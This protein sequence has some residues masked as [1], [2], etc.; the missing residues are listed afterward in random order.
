[1]CA[2]AGSWGPEESNHLQADILT[3]GRRVA[4]LAERDGIPLRLLGGVAIHLR[5]G[6][7]LHPLFRREPKDLDVVVL[8]GFGRRLTALLTS[9][10]YAANTSF[11]A[12]HGDRRL[13]FYDDQHGRQMDVFVQTFEMCH[14]LPLAERLTLEP[15]TLPL[16]ELLMTKLQIVKLN[17]KDMLDLYALILAYDVGVT[18]GPLINSARIA[19]L[20]SRDWGLFRTFQLNLNRLESAAAALALSPDERQSITQR[21]IAI[22]QAI[23]AHPKTMAWKFRAGIG[24]RVRWYEDPEEIEHA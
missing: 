13:V 19:D 3:E 17:Q 4:E 1:M 2:M 5:L 18:D 23:E 8:K 16:A 14:V 9:A 6:P 24:E 22:R 7:A 11:N 15:L 12:L 20:C 21:V 10:G